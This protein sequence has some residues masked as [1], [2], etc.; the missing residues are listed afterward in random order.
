MSETL[1]DFLNMSTKK[2]FKIKRESG[3]I[4][5]EYRKLNAVDFLYNAQTALVAALLPDQTSEQY[6]KGESVHA[7]NERL[8]SEFRGFIC[9]A[10]VSH[11]FT[12]KSLGECQEDEMPIAQALT[13]AEVFALGK[14]IMEESVPELAA[15]YFRGVGVVDEGQPTDEVATVE[16]ARNSTGE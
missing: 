2:E 12:M 6:I 3:D 13:D 14:A 1:S 8:T 5:L 16:D 15:S 11:N 9:D 10:V 4:T 7:R